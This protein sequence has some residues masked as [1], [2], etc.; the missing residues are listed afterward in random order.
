M[1]GAWLQAECTAC[2]GDAR[3]DC[4]LMVYET[5]YLLCSAMSIANDTYHVH[6]YSHT[7]E[8]TPPALCLTLRCRDKNQEQLPRCPHSIPLAHGSKERL[9][10]LY[11][12]VLN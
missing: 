12:V 10:E 3:A 4:V 6:V 8:P 11:P 1:Y 9:S 5:Y 2:T 7:D